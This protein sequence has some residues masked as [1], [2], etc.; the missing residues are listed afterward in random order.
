MNNENKKINMIQ[1]NKNQFI[2]F[3]LKFNSI[4][5]IENENEQQ[6]ENAKNVY[7]FNFH[8]FMIMMNEIKND[9][10]ITIIEHDLKNVYEFKCMILNTNDVKTFYEFD[11]SLSLHDV[12]NE[13]MEIKIKRN[14]K[15][16]SQLIIE[17][18]N[19]YDKKNGVDAYDIAY[20]TSK[21]FNLLQH[22][23]V[24]CYIHE[25]SFDVK[26]Q[27]EFEHDKKLNVH[28]QNI[29]E[30]LRLQFHQ[31]INVR[32]VKHMNYRKRKN[33]IVIQDHD[34]FLGGMYCVITNDD[35]EQN[36]TTINDVYEFI[37]KHHASKM[38]NQK[39]SK[40]FYSVYD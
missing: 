10:M 37:K 35:C 36:N 22:D 23:E 6:I 13:M 40:Q 31:S 34:S 39:R 16:K 9:S 21:H 2:S 28:D 14:E 27:Y 11:S 5:D 12:E 4:D 29:C 3:V 17:C 26:T 32:D 24:P 8:E 20:R 33:S 25:M 15:I 1:M 19:L 18:D 30:T 7:D 38:Q